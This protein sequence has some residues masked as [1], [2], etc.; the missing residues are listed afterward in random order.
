[1]RI[2]S[3][4]IDDRSYALAQ[5]CRAKDSAELVESILN[6]LNQTVKGTL[7]GARPSRLSKEKSGLDAQ[8]DLS[9]FWTI[10]EQNNAI[11]DESHS[12]LGTHQ[13]ILIVRD[14]YNPHMETLLKGRPRRAK[15]LG[16]AVFEWFVEGITEKN[17]VPVLVYPDGTNAVIKDNLLFRTLRTATSAEK[18]E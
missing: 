17:E 6:V 14:N 12:Y 3:F 11:T 18:S 15:M 13:Y 9:V 8:K 10:L 5:R 16:L 4:P 1:M 7:D 2:I